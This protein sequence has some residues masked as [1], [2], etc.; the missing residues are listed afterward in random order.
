MMRG[1]R[2]LTISM[3]LGSFAWSFVFITLPF[4]IQAISTSDPA[5]TLRWTGWILGISSL[6]TVLTGP[7]WGR[8]AAVGD[9]RVYYVAVQ[10]LQGVCFCGMAAARTLFE[11]FIARFVLGFMGATS[12]LA[13]IVVGR[14]SDPSE[15]R[16][17]V[18]GVQT[19]MTVGQVIGPLG[20][21]AAAARISFRP[22][23]VLGGLIL[24]GSAA[25][26]YWGVT[27]PPDPGPVRSPGR[28][29]HLRD[30]VVASSIV[31]AGS[32]QLFFLVSVLPQILPGLGVPAA[33][34]VETGGLLVFASAAAMAV[35]AMATPRLAALVPE[36]RLTAT[37]LVLSGAFMLGLAL[38][39]GVWSYT[40]VRFLQVL[41][42]APVFP[43]VVARIAHQT[44]GGAIGIINSARIGASFIGP[45]I[46]T[47]LL[48][49]APPVALY[50]LLAAMGLACVPL[51]LLRDPQPLD[52][53]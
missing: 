45:V 37:L 49:S 33:N 9:P 51:A 3:F 7:A 20:G 35:G 22:S 5:T 1:A 17:Q 2:A 47:S 34:L 39:T 41:C 38:S 4:H 23:F 42:I 44:S 11:L 27:V 48:A 15:V 36:R 13:F 26:V 32:T 25:F 46:A 29:A 18:A 8:L 16:R 24:L 12:T 6:V 14:E 30:V 10:V 43:L 21:A 50:A 19:A 53:T 52:E 28:R 31:L 40:V